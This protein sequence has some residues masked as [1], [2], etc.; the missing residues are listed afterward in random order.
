MRHP[1]LGQRFFHKVKKLVGII[2]FL[3]RRQTHE[4][5]WKQLF[6]RIAGGEYHR[7]AAF[8]QQ[9]GDG[10][11]QFAVEI[12]VENSDL[13]IDG[14][15]ELAHASHG[16]GGADDYHAALLK[17]HFEAEQNMR[18]ILGYQRAP[19]A[20]GRASFVFISGTS[21][22]AVN[23]FSAKSKRAT[24]EWLYSTS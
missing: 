16:R 10:K 19:C 11:N 12:D 8:D 22:L 17:E 18:R 9:I 3:Q 6:R 5:G 21:N 20:H 2:R 7:N 15:S 23:P 1:R 4:T 14:F 13:G 24:P